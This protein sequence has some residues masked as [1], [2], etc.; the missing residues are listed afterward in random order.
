LRGPIVA[1]ILAAI[2]LILKGKPRL[3]RADIRA[4][5]ALL[6]LLAAAPFATAASPEQAYIDARDHAIA[7]LKGM[8]GARQDA[9]ERRLRAGLERQLRSL[10]G[11]LRLEGFP[12]PTTM[13]PDTL[14]A[15]D[16]GFGALDGI[17][18]AA[19]DRAGNVLVT[20]DGL[21]QH[22]LSEH[23]AWWND[24]PNPPT[25]LEGA[26]RSGAFYTQAASADAAVSIFAP[27]PVHK[28]AG[29]ALAVALLVEESQDLAI[30]PPR[31]IA[32]AVVKAGRVF[33]AIVGAETKTA[34]IAACDAVW[35]GFKAKSDAALKAYDDS[36]LKDQ[37]SFDE[38]THLSG[39]GA[40]A[41]QECWSKQA[42]GE[43]EFPALTKQAQALADL[44]ASH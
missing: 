19:K 7:V 32:V 41:L 20:T 15:D 26:F 11:P 29:A 12:G 14:L 37:K 10:I 42:A 27:L 35:R 25:D 16:I 1:P 31:Q 39:K 36:G 34:P 9:E 38:S 13:S 40:A 18:L 5:I 17:S 21:L 23:K 24:E 44:F 6:I 8:S 28:P 2:P 3:W 33:I 30:E 4:I 22:W 43:R